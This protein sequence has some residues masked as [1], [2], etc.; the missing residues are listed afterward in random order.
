V[1]YLFLVQDMKRI[2]NK[3]KEMI[4][5]LCIELLCV[6]GVPQK[7]HGIF[8]TEI[9]IPIFEISANPTIQLGE[10]RS[11]RFLMVSRAE[12]SAQEEIQA[13]EDRRIFNTMERVTFLDIS[14]VSNPTDPATMIRPHYTNC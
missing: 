12:L 11:R 1:K 13:E 3:I 10:I 2:I 4:V 14:V 8:G 6:L 7:N 9:Q 5:N